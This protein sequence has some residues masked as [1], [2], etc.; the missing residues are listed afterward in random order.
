MLDLVTFREEK[1]EICD[2]VIFKTGKVIFG[3]LKF[4]F[5]KSNSVIF[6]EKNS[7]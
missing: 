3:D 1:S 2:G 6:R 5:N 7:K 4:F